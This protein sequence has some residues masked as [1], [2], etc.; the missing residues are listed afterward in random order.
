MASGLF[1]C[2]FIA[3]SQWAFAFPDGSLADW[4]PSKSHRFM[5]PLPSR[6]AGGQPAEAQ[7]IVGAVIDA[8]N[9]KY[10]AANLRVAPSNRMRSIQNM[11][12][13]Y[14]VIDAVWDQRP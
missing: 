12:Q 11:G 10:P 8:I 2:T 7:V 13:T 5:G 14:L 9:Q 4:E 1:E 6:L 3:G